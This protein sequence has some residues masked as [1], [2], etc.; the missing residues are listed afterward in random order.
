MGSGVVAIE[1]AEFVIHQEVKADYL[2][3]TTV[4]PEFN[5]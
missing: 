5:S 3:K 4:Q 2:P 1:V